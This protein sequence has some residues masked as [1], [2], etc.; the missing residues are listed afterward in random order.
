VQTVQLAAGTARQQQRE[1]ADTGH[2]TRGRH[3]KSLGTHARTQAGG[4]QN[5]GARLYRNGFCGMPSPMSS[6]YSVMQYLASV[7]AEELAMSMG[8]VNSRHWEQPPG[9]VHLSNWGR[10][11][12]DNVAWWT[13]GRGARRGR[14]VWVAVWVEVAAVQSWRRIQRD[15]RQEAATHAPMSSRGWLR[16]PPPRTG[17]RRSR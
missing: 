17:R 11:G 16:G 3:L 8:A 5:G 7:V 9:D 6:Q 10:G 12:G 15:H 13:A 4:R 1:A 14:P 2:G